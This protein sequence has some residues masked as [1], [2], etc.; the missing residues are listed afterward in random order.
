MAK[1]LKEGAAALAAVQAQADVD[2]CAV[3][4]G[5]IVEEP[6]PLPPNEYPNRRVCRTCGIEY[7]TTRPP[8]VRY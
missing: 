6:R 5:G 2:L 8:L 7:R 1:R 3:C 4:G